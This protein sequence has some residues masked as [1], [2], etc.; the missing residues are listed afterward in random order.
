MFWLLILWPVQSYRHWEHLDM[1]ES[2]W[3]NKEHLMLL[4]L[5]SFSFS[6]LSNLLAIDNSQNDLAQIVIM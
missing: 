2:F 4:I 3:F 6:N 5:S 1:I